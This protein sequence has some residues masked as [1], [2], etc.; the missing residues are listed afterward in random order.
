MI[1]LV[2]P[3]TECRTPEVGLKIKKSLLSDLVLNIFFL[4]YLI[5]ET[6]G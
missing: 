6:L 1:E 4:F 5:E 3:G 2:L